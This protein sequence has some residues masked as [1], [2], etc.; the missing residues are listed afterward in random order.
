MLVTEQTEPNRAGRM[1]RA[2]IVESAIDALVEVGYARTSIGE[3]ARRS[4]ISKGVVTYHF[5]DKAT[6]LGEVVVALY[7]QAGDEIQSTVELA[8]NGK[9]ALRGYLETNLN[10]IAAHPRHVQ[11]AIEVV[12]NLRKQDNEPAFPPSAAD[13]VSDH[14]AGLLHAGQ[15]AGQFGDFDS[16]CLALMI[17]AA[18]D[19]AATH[20]ITDPD[21]DLPAYRRQLIEFADRATRLPE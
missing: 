15:L 19:A 7:Q 11:A 6:L 14:L 8:E 21:F 2:Q 4:G 3:I 5:R 1:R 16:R 17:R 10:F 18:T 20:L 12:A 9:D 13:P